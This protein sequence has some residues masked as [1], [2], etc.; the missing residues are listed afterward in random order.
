MLPGLITVSGAGPGRGGVGVTGGVPRVPRRILAALGAVFVALVALIALAFGLS[1][2][3][4]VDAFLALSFVSTFTSG[5][6]IA[7][8]VF[9]PMV[10]I[11]SALML[12][13]V[14]KRRV[15]VYVI[16]LAAAMAFVAGVFINFNLPW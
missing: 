16:A 14:F 12:L 2:C 6:I 4:T 13:G 15:V 10:D 1:V 9:G 5:S 7:F 11:K 3:S 8:L